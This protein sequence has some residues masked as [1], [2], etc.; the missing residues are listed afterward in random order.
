[1]FPDTEVRSLRR[2]EKPTAVCV[3]VKV[4]P[5]TVIVPVRGKPVRLAVTL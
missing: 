1:M 5:S 2:G 3:I 4:I